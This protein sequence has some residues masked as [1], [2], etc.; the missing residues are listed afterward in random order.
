MVGKKENARRNRRK[1][2]LVKR[3][4]LGQVAQSRHR[5]SVSVMF[6][7]FLFVILGLPFSR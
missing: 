5:H 4:S 7:A 3:E 2:G 1:S 6:V